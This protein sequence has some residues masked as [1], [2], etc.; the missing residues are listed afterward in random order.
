MMKPGNR[1]KPTPADRLHAILG[2]MKNEESPIN[3]LPRARLA[4]ERSAPETVPDQSL[5]LKRPTAESVKR[6]FQILPAFW[7]VASVL[8]IVVNV[9]LL[10]ILIG[11]MRGLGGL[12]LGQ[13]G[14]GLVGGLYS[15]FEKMDAAHIKTTIPVQS[16]IPLNMSIPVQTTTN[17]SL[18]EAVEIPNAHVKI[19]TGTFNIDSDADVILPAGTNL[20][21]V[22]NF[23][24]PVQTTVPVGLNVP[25]DIALNKTE[26]DPA[27]TGLESTIRPLYCVLNPDAIS[28]DHVPVCK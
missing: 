16:S 12:N 19:S 18:A 6:G 8:S 15:N 23:S 7:T 25:V 3:R 22:L 9:V 4:E 24:V 5:P 27:I 20:N 21:V 26:L 2:G 17:I 13:V 10:A 28:I 1:S 14:T 11:A